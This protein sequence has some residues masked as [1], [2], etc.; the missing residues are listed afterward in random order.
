MKRAVNLSVFGALFFM[1]LLMLLPHFAPND[2]A[3]YLL[4]YSL[5]FVIPAASVLFIS[6]KL[7][8]SSVKLAV[9]PNREGAR[10]SLP[11]M[12][13]SVGVV[14]GLAAL[15]SYLLSCAGVVN[16]STV[17][18]SLTYA[19]ASYAIIPAIGEELIFRFIPLKLIAPHSKKA[20]LLVS[21]MLFSAVHANLFQIPYAFF[22][23]LAFAFIDIISDSI[24]PSVL[25]H[26]LNNMLSL[27]LNLFAFSFVL[28]L[29]L[30]V[31]AALLALS[32]FAIVLHRREYAERLRAILSEK[33]SVFTPEFL[34]FITLSLI[35]AASSAFS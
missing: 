30:S 13:P 23:G 18:G 17:S 21:A 1:L 24:A 4:L 31:L 34:A 22:A 25:V 11:L 16:N 29:I 8:N 2:G 3:L 15:T 10:L 33:A 7:G 12:L 5:S 20:A 28:N 6:A 9:F 19:F 32:V 27:V 26:L 35:L 14:I